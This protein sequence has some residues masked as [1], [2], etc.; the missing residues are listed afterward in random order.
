MI[1]TSGTLQLGD[2]LI[3]DLT[4]TGFDRSSSQESLLSICSSSSVTLSSAA[5]TVFGNLY[6]RTPGSVSINADLHVPNGYVQIFADSDANLNGAF[7]VAA[8][9]SVIVSASLTSFSVSCADVAIGNGA[10]L[11]LSTAKVSISSTS[12]LPIQFGGSP[13]S[14]SWVDISSAEAACITTST[15]WLLAAKTITIRSLAS[16]VTHGSVEL[17]ARVSAGQIT[18][19][20][21]SVFDSLNATASAGI[22][23]LAPVTTIAGQLALDG[24]YDGGGISGTSIASGQ[25][26]WAFSNLLL[27]P[28]SFGYVSV[29]APL[30]IRANRD[31]RLYANLVVI[32]TGVL[33]VSADYLAAGVGSFLCQSAGN[34]SVLSSSVDG[35]S[36][37]A[38]DYVLGSSCV[39]DAGV[40][41][42][43]VM[44]SGVSGMFFGS[45]P[46][47]CQLS[48]MEVNLL[49]TS[50]TL[51][52]GGPF[53]NNV[54]L[55]AV[56]YLRPAAG[57]AVHT[58]ATSQSSI[59]V[60]GY[61]NVSSSATASLRLVSANVVVNSSVFCYGHIFFVPSVVSNISIG[62][63]QGRF[64]FPATALNYVMST[65]TFTIGGALAQAV[66]ITPTVYACGSGTLEVSARDELPS[67][68][69]ALDANSLTVFPSTSA[70]AI[71]AWQVASTWSMA[72]SLSVPGHPS[73]AGAYNCTVSCSFGSLAV[74]Y[75][76]SSQ[77]AASSSLTFSGSLAQVQ[78]SLSTLKYS[79]NR[80]LFGG[81]AVVSTL[82]LAQGATPNGIQS[83]TT[84]IRFDDGAL[85]GLLS[86]L[87]G[88]FSSGKSDG[89]GPLGHLDN[90]WGIVMD[91]GRSRLYVSDTNNNRL[92]A[93][94]V[95]SGNLTTFAGSSS[96]FVDGPGYLARFSRP[97]GM[98][99]RSDGYLV[100]ADTENHAIRLVSP[101]GVTT[102][103][104]GGVYGAPLSRP[105]GVCVN[106]S[107][108]VVF[109]AD[110]ENNRIL[111]L[112]SNGTLSVYAGSGQYGYADSLNP[113]TARFRHPSAVA[114]DSLGNLYVADSL[115]HCIRKVST[116]G[117]VTTLAGSP[118]LH[119][120][121]DGTGAAARFHKPLS[122]VID[123]SDVLYVSDTFN[124]VIRQVT[125]SGSV[126]TI[127]GD[128]PG[129]S[130]GSSLLFGRLRFPGQVAV[131]PTAVDV[132]IADT[133]NHAIRRV[134]LVGSVPVV[135][136]I[137]PSGGTNL[138]GTVVVITGSF[139]ASPQ[140]LFCSFGTSTLYP[141]IAVTSSTVTCTTPPHATGKALVRVIN[142]F[143]YN[144]LYVPQTYFYS[145]NSVTFYYSQ[146]SLLASVKRIAPQI[147]LVSGGTQVTVF[148]SNFYATLQLRCAFGST[149][150]A[151]PGWRWSPSMI[152]CVS[153]PHAAGQVYVSLTFD[154]QQYTSGSPATFTYAP[155][156]VVSS[157]FPTSGPTYYRT[158]VSITG[159]GFV[160][161][162]SGCC[163]FGIDRVPIVFYSSTSI[164]CVTPSRISSLTDPLVVTVNGNW[165]EGSSPPSSFT[166]L[167]PIR[168]FTISPAL[169]PSTGGTIVNI[170]GANLGANSSTICAFGSGPPVPAL[171]VTST[172]VTC[173]TPAQGEDLVPVLLGAPG[174]A[175]SRTNSVFRFVAPVVV[176]SVYPHFGPI[177]GG[178]PVTVS[179]AN[180]LSEAT[181]FCSFSGLGTVDARRLSTTTVLCYS[182]PTSSPTSSVVRVTSNAVDYSTTSAVFSYKPVVT[183]ASITPAVGMTFT[184]TAV[185]ITGANFVFSGLLRVQFSEFLLV[186]PQ[187]VSSSLLIC[188]T[189]SARAPANSTVRVLNNGLQASAS[190]LV[191]QF[192]DAVDVVSVSPSSGPNVGGTTVYV[193]LG[194]ALS[195]QSWTCAFTA[196]NDS[197]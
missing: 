18:F 47:L 139:T 123:S 197:T 3:S 169:G 99:L 158:L 43:T 142:T 73:N 44:S 28:R 145:S 105:S 117:A 50:G 111:T 148:G 85:D 196:V 39:V 90:P 42:L 56:N 76:S 137:S 166:F 131:A 83:R 102:T 150:N 185:T 36:V 151:V 24:C 195:W 53:V 38:A 26:L 22:S 100:I 184:E 12:T 132:F 115:N 54:T 149:A 37:S 67:L 189:P 112:L 31:V 114:V 86:T 179:G 138:G 116:L 57:V 110:T 15:S 9:T 88:S 174:T 87:S 93:V 167:K 96:G 136:A 41:S 21:N 72:L 194:Q 69:I 92:C 187:F 81:D 177:T 186:R 63:F 34:V 46:G 108:A 129:S 62:S 118:Y 191:F 181:E 106:A 33:N 11:A 6:I 101:V 121:A 49:V 82:S 173:R 146:S 65:N 147:G 97:R 95:E 171:E 70:N 25:T 157:I 165:E 23:V 119:G 135:T 55:S 162:D 17:D 5:T 45:A 161:G 27:H 80:T 104:V 35:V 7:V 30:A 160:A 2:T 16:G 125:T 170:T 168:T 120:F 75:T 113:R 94:D 51:T 40:S 66:S 126:T 84:E 98:F 152:V 153:P 103:L 89:L 109:I 10:S 140:D 14:G 58:S 190:A 193:N 156:P 74:N 144:N 68:G 77:S 13:S 130:D 188:V 124:H 1:T 164:A 182:P 163:Y 19:S 60:A 32:G 71:P 178:T 180:F 61:F 107:N 183:L 134:H 4:I 192:V 20:G 159:S 141:A 8:S 64:A 133:G 155:R 48:N 127:A 172:W 176:L 78:F 143:T 29:S 52:L 91:S 154:G 128:T 175:L 59:I 79:R 122:V